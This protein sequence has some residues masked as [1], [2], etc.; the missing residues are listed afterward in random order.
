MS[1]N[2]TLLKPLLGSDGARLGGLSTKDSAAGTHQPRIPQSSRRPGFPSSLI[3]EGGIAMKTILSRDFGFDLPYRR[4]I[5]PR[6][7]RMKRIV[8]R[9]T[10][11]FWSNQRVPGSSP[12][13]LTTPFLTA[14]LIF[15]CS[16][17]LGSATLL[18]VAVPEQVCRTGVQSWYPFCQCGCH[19]P[20][21]CRRN[22]AIR[23][24]ISQQPKRPQPRLV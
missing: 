15:S 12:G 1:F 9:R 22:H 23:A 2:G 6:R 7:F 13:R 24:L 3:R 5:H 19:A 8:L 10:I 21:S 17:V 16:D 20:D 11:F 4:L 18:G 14:F